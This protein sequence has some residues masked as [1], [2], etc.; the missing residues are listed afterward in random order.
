MATVNSLV[1]AINSLEKVDLHIAV[2]SFAALLSLPLLL[3][4]LTVR[5]WLGVCDVG[6]VTLSEVL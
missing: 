4:V 6:S 1:S 5:H 3:P 2:R